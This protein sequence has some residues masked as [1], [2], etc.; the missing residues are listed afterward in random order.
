MS[1]IDVRFIPTPPVTDD[2]LPAWMRGDFTTNYMPAI[3]AIGH[4]IK[5]TNGFQYQVQQV[6]WTHDLATHTW[7]VAIQ[8][9]KQP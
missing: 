4:H 8:V 6:T 9:G 1:L 2:D 5:D 3:P 7:Y